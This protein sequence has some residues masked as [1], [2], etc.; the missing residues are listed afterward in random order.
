MV[1]NEEKSSSNLSPGNNR[2]WPSEDILLEIV[3]ISESCGAYIQG[4][5]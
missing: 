1:E 5:Q 3:G 2:T 4:L